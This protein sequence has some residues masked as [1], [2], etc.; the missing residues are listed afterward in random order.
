MKRAGLAALGAAVVIAV[1][2]CGGSDKK[3]KSSKTSS[4]ATATTQSTKAD[5]KAKSKL[6][7]L[8]GDYNR[9]QSRF[10]RRVAA[11][12]RAQNL[13]AV[14]ADASQFRDAVFAFDASVRKVHVSAAKQSQVNAVLAGTRTIIGELDAIGSAKD[15]VEVNKLFKRVLRDKAQAISAFNTLVRAL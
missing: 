2:G 13:T 5:P 15:F 10:L 1:G 14:K 8:G 6:L 9:A 7:T 12:A 3:D 4:T 11:D